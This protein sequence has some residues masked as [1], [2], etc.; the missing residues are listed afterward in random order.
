MQPNEVI[1]IGSDSDDARSQH[2]DGS[3][4]VLVSDTHSLHNTLSRV[5]SVS[6]FYYA[7]Q[8]TEPPSSQPVEPDSDVGFDYEYNDD[9][10]EEPAVVPIK[11]TI[12]AT[13]RQSCI[14]NEDESDDE[15]LFKLSTTTT[16]GV[17]QLK[18]KA[19]TSSIVSRPLMEY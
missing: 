4:V 6:S 15:D 12:N 3:D 11:N 9:E 2:S 17:N 10:D 5:S 7:S 8:A 13:T 18:R 1:E 14:L 16:T 19:S